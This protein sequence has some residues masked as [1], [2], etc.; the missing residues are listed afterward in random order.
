MWLVKSTSLI[1]SEGFDCAEIGMTKVTEVA[2]LGHTY[3]L[4]CLDSDGRRSSTG[5]SLTASICLVAKIVRFFS[6]SIFQEK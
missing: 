5:V 6:L 4:R 1:R 2:E 3:G